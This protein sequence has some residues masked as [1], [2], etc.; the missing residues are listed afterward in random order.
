MSEDD[1][2]NYFLQ[3]FGSRWKTLKEALETNN[4]TLDYDT[5]LLKPYRMDIASQIAALALNLPGTG[6]VLDACAAPGGKSLVI[7][8]RIESSVTLL[9]NELSSERRRRLVNVLDDHLF[10]EQR[11][12]VRVSGFDAAAAGRRVSEHGRFNAILLDAPCSS[13]RHLIKNKAAMAKWTLARIKYLASRQW[14]LLSSAFLLLAP[15]G[16]LVYSTCALSEEENDGPVNRLFK[17]YDGQII[18]DP[19]ILQQGSE[20]TTR[21]IIFLPDRADGAGPMYIA[22]VR[23]LSLR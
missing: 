21:G 5:K 16:S 9:A 6:E 3:K 18:D 15:G 7:A 20:K 12:R 13:E 19:C 1:F 8:S 23:K 22:R 10:P 14:A 17:K 4:R 11:S 2:N